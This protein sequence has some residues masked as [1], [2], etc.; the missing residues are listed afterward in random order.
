MKHT[1]KVS[2]SAV[3]V[4]ENEKVLLE[5]ENFGQMKDDLEY[6]G[7]LSGGKEDEFAKEL[8]K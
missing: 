2:L 4:G 6:F 1:P 5:V 3:D 7:M 8:E